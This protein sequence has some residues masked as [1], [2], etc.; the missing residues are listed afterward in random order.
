MGAK[1]NKGAKPYKVDFNAQSANYF[2]KIK[3]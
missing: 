1:L 3:D 2:A